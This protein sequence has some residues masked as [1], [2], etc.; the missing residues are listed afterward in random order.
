MSAA[1]GLVI[2]VPLA[3][4]LAAIFM[5][6]RARRFL[7]GPAALATGAAVVI[8]AT[9]VWTGGPTGMRLGGWAPPLGIRLYADGF[10]LFM[11][12]MAAVVAGLVSLYAIGYFR[13][14]RH[15]GTAHERRLFWPL[16]FFLWAAL[17][18]LFVAADLFSIYVLFELLGLAAIG[19]V[20]A[21]G[22]GEVL[23]AAMRYLVAALLGSLLYLMGTALIYAEHGMLDLY[24]LGEVVTGSRADVL[25][26][27][28]MAV[29]L[30]LKTALFPLHFWLPPAHANASSPVSAV[31]SA[32]V[33][34]AS[35]FILARLWF[36]VFREIIPAGA[37]HLLGVLGCAA[38]LWGSLQ[39]MRQARLK[40]LIAYSTVAQVGYMFLLFPLTVFTAAEMGGTDAAWLKEAPTATVYQIV[41]HALVKS[42]MFLVAGLVVAAVGSDRIRSL[43]G[44]SRE[45]P[46]ATFALAIAG[47]NLIGLPP[48]S[49]FVAKF[50]LIKA[51]LGSGQWWWVPVIVLGG[52][53]TAGYIVLMLRHAFEVKGGEVVR[54]RVRR[55]M[56]VIALVLAVLAML[57]GFRLDEPLR[58]LFIGDPFPRMPGVEEVSALGL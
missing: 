43:R 14:G 52:L 27:S 22:K 16:W 41:S 2:L 36:E 13:P 12:L 48:S 40:P 45:M 3:G 17:N 37:G 47:M 42:T 4:G 34:K 30:C 56:E 15:A 24:L 50:L 33:I 51:A 1:L 25:A 31:L 26:F 19:L 57:M 7:A 6:E 18:S 10:S 44:L 8:L 39:A 35:F 11:L 28:L 49:G 46:I 5:E 20:A 32:L 38:I 53:I 23:T 54:T 21:P 55:S 29:G 58:L 9:Q